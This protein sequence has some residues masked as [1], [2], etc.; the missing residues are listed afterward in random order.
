MSH[1]LTK[2][3][4]AIKQVQEHY[5]EGMLTEQDVIGDIALLCSE[6]AD[7]Y[8]SVGVLSSEVPFCPN[9]S[10]MKNLGNGSYACG[11]GL[12]RK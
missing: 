11:C 8:S 2:F 10:A 3:F 9:H 12:V 5:E 7:N 6:E 4:D 1:P